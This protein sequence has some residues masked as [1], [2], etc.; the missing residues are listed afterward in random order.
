MEPSKIET[1]RSA[2][3]SAAGDTEGL[4]PCYAPPPFS[5]TDGL[6]DT[7]RDAPA[8]IREQSAQPAGQSVGV[9]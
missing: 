8:G 1:V 7:A 9:P 3:E 2:A 6:G 4:S 5:A